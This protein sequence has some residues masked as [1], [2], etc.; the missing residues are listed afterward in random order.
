MHLDTLGALNYFAAAGTTNQLYSGGRSYYVSN[1]HTASTAARIVIQNRVDV[2][3]G[4]NHVQ[5]T[6]DG[7]VAAGVPPGQVVIQTAIIG[8]QTG[9]FSAQTFPLRFTSPQ[10][11][12]SVR[13]REKLRWNAGYQRYGYAEEFGIYQN[14]RAHTGYSSVSWSF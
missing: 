9:F 10:G 1:L 12:V 5:D 11:R 4:F 8:P 13:I 14:F 2:S 3:L 6:G 7:R